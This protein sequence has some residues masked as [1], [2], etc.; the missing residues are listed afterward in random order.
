MRNESGV[1]IASGIVRNHHT[2]DLTTSAGSL[3]ETRVPIQVSRTHVL[4]EAPD[5]W[6]Y[7][8]RPWPMGHVIYR[9]ISPLHHQQQD[10]YTTFI[11]MRNRPI[12]VS[13]RSYSSIVRVL[14]V[15]ASTKS[16]V[17]LSEQSV[18]SI[19][20]NVCCARS[21]VQHFQRQSSRS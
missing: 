5:G 4:T 21:C 3:S 7:C 13:S 6:R 8:V 18:N 19:A 17:L 9:G 1:T 20:G 16:T 2:V 15:T 14:S 12:G 11:A 10:N